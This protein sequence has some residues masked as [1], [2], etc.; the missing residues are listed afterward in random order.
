MRLYE[1][2]SVYY[3]CVRVR[4]CVSLVATGGEK[5]REEKD[6]KQTSLIVATCC[7]SPFFI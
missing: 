7:F 5:A 1:C 3:L 6:R 2:M 4:L